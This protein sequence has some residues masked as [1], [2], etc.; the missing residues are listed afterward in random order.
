MSSSGNSE[1]SRVGFDFE[2]SYGINLL[3]GADIH[4]IIY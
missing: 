3:D 4:L 2:W 1:V